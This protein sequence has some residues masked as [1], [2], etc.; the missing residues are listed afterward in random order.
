[1]GALGTDLDPVGLRQRACVD[2]EEDRGNLDRNEHTVARGVE[3]GPPR[4]SRK[5]DRRHDVTRIDSHD[6]SGGACSGWLAEV[7]AVEVAAACVEREPVRSGPDRDLREKRFVGAAEDAHPRGAT[8][9]R[10]QAI[11]SAVDEHAGDA[12]Q[13]GQRAEVGIAAAVEHVD[14]IHR[15]VRDVQPATAPIQVRVGVIE[16]GALTARKCNEAR[17]SQAQ[18]GMASA[19]F[20]Q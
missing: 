11:R 15:R 18:A 1:M 13:V 5:G 8:V 20:W 4:S 12:G 9:G 2:G 19:R 17:R 16:S 6:G 14:D 10:E 7:E 3:D